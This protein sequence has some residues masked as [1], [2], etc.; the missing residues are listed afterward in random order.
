MRN[1]VRMFASTA[2]LVGALALAGCGG[3]DEP[4]VGTPPAAPTAAQAGGG[5]VAAEPVDTC[6]LFTPADAATVLGKQGLQPT[7]RKA[8]GSLLGGCN[9]TSAD[10]TGADITARPA[11]EWD[12]TKKAYNGTPVSGVG[13]EAVWADKVGLLVLPE[14]KPYFLHVLVIAKVAP[15]SLDKDGSITAGK[16]A[17]GR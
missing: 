2:G 13:K 6:A 3:S 14:G 7:S 17:A 8:E 16:I 11:K 9:Y 1:S 5:P 12:A 10:G 15:L 4:A